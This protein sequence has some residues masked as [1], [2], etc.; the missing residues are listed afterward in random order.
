MRLTYYKLITPINQMKK[1]TIISL[2]SFSFLLISS[3]VFANSYPYPAV[4]GTAGGV[5]STGAYV[6]GDYYRMLADSTPQNP[7]LWSSFY[8]EYGPTNS[9]GNEVT[10]QPVPTLVPVTDGRSMYNAQLT[11]LQSSTTYYYRF[12]VSW[13]LQN[14]TETAYFYGNTFTFTTFGNSVIGIQT[15][16]ATNLTTTSAFINGAF[17]PQI[18]SQIPNPQ[19]FHFDYGTSLALGNYAFAQPIMALVANPDGSTRY[20]AALSN[21]VPGTT[22]YYRFSS[23]PTGLTPPGLVPFVGQTLSFTALPSSVF[24]GGFFTTTLLFGSTHPEVTRLQLCL[25]AVTTSYGASTPITGGFYSITDKALREYQS[26]HGIDPIGIVGPLTRA[27]LNSVC[28]PILN[29]AVSASAQ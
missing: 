15:L 23:G 16:P 25:R 28:A 8:F 2:L 7:V 3:T 24:P 22:Y 14:S 5:T 13:R 29:G 6:S 19:E 21:L 9:F 11:N 10:A 17:F 26:A 18:N 1:T 12:V 4:T 20:T 27:S